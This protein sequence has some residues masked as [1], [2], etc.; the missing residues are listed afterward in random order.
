MVGI[1]RLSTSST[2]DQEL[3][4]H[5]HTELSFLLC[6]FLSREGCSLEFSPMG[7]RFLED[8][9]VVPVHYTAF[10]ND[11]KIVSILHKELGRKVEKLK[12]MK[13][14]VMQPKIKNK[15]E[16]PARE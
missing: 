10:S 3:V 13:L 1:Y 2:Q 7:V 8:G 14:E 16:L 11:Q 15:S 12:H 6:K 4:G 5:L 9:L